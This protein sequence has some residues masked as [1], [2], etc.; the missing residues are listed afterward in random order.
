MA[1]PNDAAHPQE[2]GRR[3]NW[4]DEHYV[5]LYTRDTVTWRSFP[6]QARCLLPLFLKAADG[7][8]V[9][10]TGGKDRAAGLAVLIG[11]PVEV[12][13]PGLE[14]L[15]AEG[16]V[17]HLP[18]GLLMPKFIEAQEAR[19]T[20]T[21]RKRDQREREIAKL[22][23]VKSAESQPTDVTRRHTAS[24]PVT[25]QPSP[26]QPSPEK[27][28]A[29][30]CPPSARRTSGRAAASVATPG[31]VDSCV[32]TP[33]GARPSARPGNWRTTTAFQPAGARCPASCRTR[34]SPGGARSGAS[35]SGAAWW[36]RYGVRR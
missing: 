27:L 25:L 17:E 31:G 26:A 35:A 4:P 20:D 10:E 28:A 24:H 21:L 3:L 8:G 7:A 14:A 34:K 16:V 23:L 2:K 13:A 5:K 12:V 30:C 15:V 11:V 32:R 18:N 6:W 29:D 19:K 1:T 9:I 36:G 33:R 22:R